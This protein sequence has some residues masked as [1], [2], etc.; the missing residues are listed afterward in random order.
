MSTDDKGLNPKLGLETKL[1]LYYLGH[2]EELIPRDQEVEA[3]VSRQSLVGLIY[4][5]TGIPGIGSVPL[6]PQ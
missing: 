5:T 2:K 6:I 1:A 4:V 3:E